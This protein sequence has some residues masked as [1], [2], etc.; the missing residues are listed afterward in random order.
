MWADYR[1]ML[2][3]E[4]RRVRQLAGCSEVD[5]AAIL[6]MDVLQVLRIERGIYPLSDEVEAVWF[7]A[8]GFEVIEVWELIGG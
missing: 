8:H 2:A 3:A 5:S 7:H 4:R 1:R 6:G